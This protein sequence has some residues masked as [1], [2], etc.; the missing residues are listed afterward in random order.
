MFPHSAGGM[1]AFCAA[2]WS[3]CTACSRGCP[4]WQVGLQESGHLTIIRVRYIAFGREHVHRMVQ[5]SNTLPLL[6]TVHTGFGI[7]EASSPA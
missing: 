1:P 4:Y 6:S 3:T 2:P 5:Y 7:I